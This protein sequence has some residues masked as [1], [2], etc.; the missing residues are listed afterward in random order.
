MKKYD[1]KIMTINENI[2]SIEASSSKEAINKAKELL[3]YSGLKNIEVD[4][5]TK[6]YVLINLVNK[7]FINKFIN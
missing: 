3:Y 4:G 7:K 5:I 6:H 2:L 1:V